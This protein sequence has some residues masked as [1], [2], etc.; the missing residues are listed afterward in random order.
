MKKEGR[1]NRWVHSDADGCI[2]GCIIASSVSIANMV[3]NEDD[4]SVSHHQ[5]IRQHRNYGRRLRVRR[6]IGLT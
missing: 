2:E 6:I 5:K 1:Y 3:K 4:K